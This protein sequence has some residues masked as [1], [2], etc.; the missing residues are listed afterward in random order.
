MLSCSSCL[1]RQSLIPE[2]QFALGLLA[3]HGLANWL[4]RPVFGAIVRLC[5]VLLVLV[6]AV[7]A[8]VLKYFLVRFNRYELLKFASENEAAMDFLRMAAAQP[9]WLIVWAGATLAIAWG[10]AA[11]VAKGRAARPLGSHFWTLPLFGG[12]ALTPSTPVNFHTPYIVSAPQAFFA[13]QPR[14]ADYP[15]GFDVPEATTPADGADCVSA[16]GRRAPIVLVIVESLSAY[17]S[18]AWSGLNDWTPQLD[19]LMHDGRSFINFFANGTSTEDGLVALLTGEPPI[20]KPERRTIF[21]QF[22]AV[23]ETVPRALNELGY[24][25]AFLTTGNL[26][27]LDKGTWLKSIGFAEAEGHD[28]PGY[29]GLPR[30]HFDAATDDALY[31]RTLRWMEA[32]EGNPFF[33]MLETVSSH[34]PYVDPSTGIKSIELAFRYAD[35]AL[36]RFVTAL[37]R[38]GYLDRGYLV[39][40]GDHRAM[41]PVSKAESERYGDRAYSRVPLL[42]LGPSSPG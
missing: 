7:D 39:V 13:S 18:R 30:F 3:L 41:V 24:H 2:A 40:M 34:Q 1:L 33:L 28:Y 26:G 6:S 21:R 35:A 10:F 8:I 36:G 25:T 5:L 32:N 4:G 42:L 27:F 29:R 23:K 15:Q 16:Q 22:S 37:R 12:M 14:L 17:H 31:D 20:P 19:R 9:Y 11:Y 38:T